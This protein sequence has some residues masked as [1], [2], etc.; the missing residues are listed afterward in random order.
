MRDFNSNRRTVYLTTIR[1]DRAGYGPLFDVA[2]ST[3]L[4][5]R[6]TEST[7][8]PQ[9]LFLLNHPFVRTQAKGLAQRLEKMPG[10]DSD[11]LRQAYLLL[12]SRPPRAAEEKLGL[13]YLAGGGR[14]AD[15]CH[16]LLCA[17][18]LLYID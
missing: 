17:N 5:D 1:S 6:R 3:A 7:V 16:L 4:V 12:Y 11:R 10:T 8:A 18:E 2:D 9:A 14:W 15:Y 13:D